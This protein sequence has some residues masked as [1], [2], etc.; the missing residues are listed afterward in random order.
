MTRIYN[1]S[2]GKTLKVHMG[3][4]IEYTK[5]TSPRRFKHIVKFTIG[6]RTTSFSIYDESLYVNEKTI[7][8]AVVE[9]LNMSMAVLDGCSVADFCADNGYDADNIDME[10]GR[11]EYNYYNRIW[12]RLNRIGFTDSEII[13]LSQS[14]AD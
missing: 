11:R 4:G 12:S 10:R 14:L 2:G 6:Q 3:M 7:R 5:L 1:L 8:G 13:N 9:I